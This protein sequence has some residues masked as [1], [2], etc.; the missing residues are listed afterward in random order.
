MI[1][2]E[3]TRS[4][5][6]DPTTDHRSG[7]RLL[8]GY[9]AAQRHIADGSYRA[10]LGASGAALLHAVALSPGERFFGE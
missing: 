4:E 8:A 2:A 1:C 9:D 6:T 7:L 10:A 5:E 3:T